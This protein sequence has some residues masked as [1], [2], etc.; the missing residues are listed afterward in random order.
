MEQAHRSKL[1]ARFKSH[2]RKAKVICLD[3]PDNY[4]F[5]D[6]RL[7]EVLQDKVPA[8]LPSRK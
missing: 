5:M 8:H 1:S 7:I 2:L 4:E 6:P 3:I